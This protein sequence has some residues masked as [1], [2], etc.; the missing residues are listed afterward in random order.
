MV[1]VQKQLQPEGWLAQIDDDKLLA[2]VRHAESVG[3]RKEQ[4]DVAW[5]RLTKAG[6][7]KPLP[8]A[9]E[10]VRRQLDPGW[11]MEVD[12]EA[13]LQAM[14]E[15][16]ACGGRH[17]QLLEAARARLRYYAKEKVLAA[18]HPHWFASVK[19][20]KLLAAVKHAEAMGVAR[21]ELQ[22][23]WR[24]LSDLG[25]NPPSPFFATVVEGPTKSSVSAVVIDDLKPTRCLYPPPPLPMGTPVTSEIS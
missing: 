21:G 20:D 6:H 17:E 22:A 25:M 4:L 13:L 7:M 18:L 16:E 24:K 5:T 23:A 14:R 12:A 8:A 10:R 2:G 3:V 11:F 15:A 19:P 1:E 9:L